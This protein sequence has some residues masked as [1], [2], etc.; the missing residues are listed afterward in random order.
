MTPRVHSCKA[1]GCRLAVCL[2]IGAFLLPAT[3]GQ[4]AENEGADK[5]PRKLVY[6][7]EPQ[8]PAELKRAYIGG[9]VRLDVMISPRGTV[10]TV[11]IAGG[12]PVL[13]ECAAKAVK[14]WKYA[15]ADAQTSVRLNVKF[16][17][18]H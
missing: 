3:P 5:N 4:R 10:Q 2:V 9:M 6:K 7:V 16:D 14:Q 8:Y 18:R 11:S 1:F 15:P 12:N 17:P 13:A